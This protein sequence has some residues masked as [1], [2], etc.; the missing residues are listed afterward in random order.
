M[1]NNQELLNLD[2]TAVVE[3]LNKGEIL[4]V[5]LLDALE[6]RIN[7]VE[8]HVNALPTLCMQRARDVATRLSQLPA[9]E[10]GPLAGLPVPIK[11]LNPVAGVR[12]TFGSK[13]HENFIPESSDLVVQRLERN[14]AAIYAKSNTPEFGAGGNTFNDVFGITRNPFDLSRSPGGSSGGAAV[15]LVTGEAWLAHGSDMAG[16]LRTP[17]S[18][19]GVTSLRPSPGLIATGPS[20]LP[21]EVLGQN[22]PMARNIADL[23]L[24]TDAMAGVDSGAALSKHAQGSSFVEA[25]S[26]P[27]QPLRIAYSDDL[28][29]T[30]TDAEVAS[31]C[32]AAVDQLSNQGTVVDESHPDLTESHFAFDVLR[33]VAYA[34]GLGENLDQTRELI[35]PEVVWNVE[36]GLAATGDAILKAMIAQGRVF[37]NLADFLQDYDF[38]AAPAACVAPMPVEE[39]YIGYSEG[40]EIPEYY[41]WLAIA[42][43][44]TTA[45]APVVTLPCGVTADGMPVGLQLIGKAHD[46]YNLLSYASHIESTFDWKRPALDPMLQSLGL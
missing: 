24:F 45:T 35:K 20:L 1:E 44:S 13:V 29:V 36:Q 19:C 22:G 37:Q 2:A 12:T 5:E 21:F 15:A 40:L 27:R 26:S 23:A 43:A 3:G 10:R 46:E 6:D 4:P 38:I 7:L 9:L 30:E 8:P 11:D 34:S 32:R 17:A 25:A 39:R 42:Y 33:S 14:G 16:S 31:I 18:F 41:R 28:G